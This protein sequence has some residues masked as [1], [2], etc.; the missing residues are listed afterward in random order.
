MIEIVCPSCHARY[1]LPDGSIGPEGR[2][3][4]CSSCSHK[5][6]ALEAGAAP[7]PEQS[8]PEQSSPV[9][10]SG[11]EPEPVAEPVAVAVA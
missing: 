3:V 8:S 5:W 6:R 1:Q 4:S 10:E 2:K 9:A 11:S 7:V